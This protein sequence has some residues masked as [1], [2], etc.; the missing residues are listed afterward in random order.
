VDKV[1][2]HADD[3]VC[4]GVIVAGIFPEEFQER[5]IHQ[6]LLIVQQ[7]EHLDQAFCPSLEFKEF[8]Y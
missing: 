4:I 7:T 2:H 3:L 6:C 8:T 5:G 1:I